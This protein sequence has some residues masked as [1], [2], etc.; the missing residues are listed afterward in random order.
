MIDLN[1][2]YQHLL[3]FIKDHIPFHP[4]I[5]IILGSGLGEFA[6]HIDIVK[7][8]RTSE[9]PDYPAST[10][11]GHKG[12][13]HFAEI[14][15]KRIIIFQGRIHFYE[16]YSIDEC[17]L[18]SFISHKLGA[19][20]LLVTNA[21]G[22]VNLN[23]QPGDL[24]LVTDF[25]SFNIKKEI[26]S[27]LS[28]P[29]IK[30]KK[31]ITNNFPSN[32]FNEIIKLAATKENICLKEGSYWYGKGPSYETPAEIR[33]L[34]KFG[35]DAVGMSTVH[36]ALFAIYH[37]IDVSSISLITNYAAGL[38]P[39]K[40]SHNEVIETANKAKNKFENLVK[41]IIKLI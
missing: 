33:M 3:N 18:P 36:E 11:E 40:L 9:I 26:S 10:V 28:F 24:M 35:V 39:N 29:T 32:S 19:S 14:Y 21:A 13:I 4:E 2:K 15:G 37:G 31:Q 1:L 12:F 5:S 22:G 8:I 20:K 23:F 25:L 16:G 27:I 34:S 7:S 41:T 38:S 6:N 17:V 30:I